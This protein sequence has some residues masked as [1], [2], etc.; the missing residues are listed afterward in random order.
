MVPGHPELQAALIAIL[1]YADMGRGRI[2]NASRLTAWRWVKQAAFWGE[3]YG[4]LTPAGASGLKRSRTA[5]PATYFA[6]LIDNR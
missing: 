6:W 4:K 3:V 1:N 5:T 2:V